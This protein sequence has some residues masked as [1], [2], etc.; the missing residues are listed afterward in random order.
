MTH[1]GDKS[2]LGYL[3]SF[4]GFAIINI[5][6]IHSVVAALV[7]IDS[8]NMGNPIALVNEVLFH[9]STIYFAVISG[10]L[11]SIILKGKGYSRFYKSK[12]TNVIFPYIFITV[13][14]T[15][16]KVTNAEET[17]QSEVLSYF[18][19]LGRDLLYGKASGV[20][21][22]MPVLFFLYI[23]TPAVN[24]LINLKKVGHFFLVILIVA[25][26]I[27][28]RVQMAFDYILS[29][30]TMI[31]FTG[32]YTFG[33]FIGSNMEATLAKVKDHFLPLVII[34]LATTS[35][36]TYLY[37]YD[38][39]MIGFISLKETFFYIQ[40]LALTLIFIFLFQQSQHRQSRWLYRIADDSFAIYFIHSFFVFGG[41]PLF[42]FLLGF[43]E[44]APFNTII[45]SIV[46]FLFSVG[47]SMGIVFLFR[48]LLG[49]KSRML[50]GA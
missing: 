32:A 18:T 40:K 38:I 42:M 36:L 15:I 1:S 9:D 29:I 27:I 50:V 41:I 17:E 7:A 23:V 25:P 30:Q 44:I 3:H 24:F 35:I 16:F 5:V 46:L 8:M 19:V 10:V 2:F 12:V 31:Y 26:L 6:Y 11:F 22:Y 45:G 13:I 49:K 37:V 48:K 47:I 4:R 34:A 14:V 43:N 33:M 20:F 28:S 39:D 21:W